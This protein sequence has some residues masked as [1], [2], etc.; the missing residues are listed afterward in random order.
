MKTRLICVLVVL[1]A[2]LGTGVIGAGATKLQGGARGPAAQMITIVGEHFGTHT[3]L[4]VS[5]NPS[6]YG[7]TVTFTATVTS[8][9]RHKKL[10]GTVRFYVTN[11]QVDALTDGLIVVRHLSGL[12]GASLKVSFTTTSLG[13]GPHSLVARY[14]GGTGFVRSASKALT[15]TVKK[16]TTTAAVLSSASMAVYGQ[17]VTFTATAA[18]GAGP[19][20]LTGTVQFSDGPSMLGGPV[21]VNSSGGG[22]AE[23]SVAL[24]GVGSHVITAT[25]SGDANHTSS[26]GVLT[27]TVTKANTATAASSSVSSSAA[28]STVTFT[29]TVGPVAPGAGQPT[30]SV[31]FK[32]GGVHVA[33]GDL[34]GDGKVTATISSPAAG[35]GSITATY[36]GDGNFLSSTSTVKP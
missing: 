4:A 22:T 25:Y 14:N 27:Q 7:Q 2:G 13:A 36:S 12:S 24:L 32:D 6:V 3:V 9:S 30:G 26:A 29:A 28:G 23:S 33:A 16:A 10:P 18:P 21:V 19:V 5:A 8:S 17:P 15:L 20:N 31:E 1:S 35:M 11:G 34:N